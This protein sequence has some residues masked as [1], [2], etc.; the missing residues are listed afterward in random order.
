MPILA[1]VQQIRKAFGAR[2]LFDGLSFALESGERVGLIG[3][4]GAGKST[5][6][7]VLAGRIGPDQGS[8]AFS[9]GLRVGFL[10]QVPSFAPGTTVLA[11]VLE[12]AGGDV[13]DDWEAHALAA[14]VMAKLSLED[15]PVDTLSG[16]W[17]KRV[18]LARELVRRP[19]LLLLDEPTN[20]LDVESI[21]WLERF[22][23][24][25]SFATLTVTHDRVFLQRVSNRILELDRRNPGGILSVK[26]D[27]ARFLETKESMLQAQESREKSLK[28]RLRR[29]TE[30]L[31]QGAK[32]RTTKQQARITRA[33]DLA[34]EVGELEY[35]NRTR[36]A[37]IDFQGADRSPK[38]LLEAKSIAKSYGGRVLFRDLDLR[39]GP[40]TRVGLMGP[41][42]CG[43][44]TLIRVLLGQEPADSGEVVRSDQLQVAHFEQNRESLDPEKTLFRTICPTG[45]H[46]TYRG[47]RIHVRSF[48]DRF[49]FAHDQAEMTV[50]KLSGGEQARVLLA[51]L[52]LQECNVLVLDEPTNDLDLETL[53]VIQDSLIDFPGAII[54]VTHDRYFL[55]Q[56]ATQ[57][58]AFPLDGSGKLT[59]CVGLAQWESWHEGEVASSDRKAGGRVSSTPALA[60][61]L[62]PS[63]KRK[64]GY[65]EQR[66]F[67]GMEQ[68]IHAAEEK[69]ALL[70]KESS[71]PELA[72]DAG[73]LAELSSRMS[74]AQAE[75]D[76]LYARWAELTAKQG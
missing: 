26:G 59:P 56:V 20:H 17:K 53:D 67:D 33:G 40:G 7:K 25:S 71:R 13:A 46:V 9:R 58:L 37:K 60:P 14:E 36:S 18:A 15:G 64:L 39:L 43:K 11:T 48:L 76:R 38:K 42:G 27:Y 44:S 41:N 5:L 55:D 16:G 32:A 68:S 63:A 3:P 69:L 29:E 6:L 28:N 31:R 22:L 52:M 57:I 54:L 19:D 75:V 62:A 1:S 73:K 70:A 24:S 34:E 65:L 51:L 23:A 21:L 50:G 4:N 8:V 30:W 74:A 2:P 12:G 61:A 49:L 10:E 72:S 45:D 35:R 47:A 66:E